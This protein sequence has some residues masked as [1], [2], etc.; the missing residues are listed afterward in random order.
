MQKLKIAHPR[1]SI[2]PFRYLDLQIHLN[3]KVL[4]AFVYQIV[5]VDSNGADSNIPNSDGF[6]IGRMML[7]IY[8]GI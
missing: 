6:Q 4:R 5:W 8:D 2:Q 7:R 3:V 1:E